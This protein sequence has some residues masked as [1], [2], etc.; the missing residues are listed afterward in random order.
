VQKTEDGQAQ[1]RYLM[2][3]RGA[4]VCRLSL[5]TKVDGFPDLGI[6]TDSSDLV[7]WT[8]KSSRRSL[9]LGLKPKRASICQLHHK[10]EEGGWCGTRVEI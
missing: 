3:G 10:T 4:W 2:A 1:V 6:K 9:G 7:I 5:K 8:S